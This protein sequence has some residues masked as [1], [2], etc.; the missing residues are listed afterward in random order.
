MNDMQNRRNQNEREDDEYALPPRS[1]LFPSEKNK[2]TLFFYRSLF[3]IF[4]LLT[5]AL[6]GWGIMLHGPFE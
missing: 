4:L 2:V 5:A 6:I 3:V 1:T